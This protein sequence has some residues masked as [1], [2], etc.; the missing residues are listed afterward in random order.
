MKTKIA[1]LL[2]VILATTG[3]GKSNTVQWEY[4]TIFPPDQF[5]EEEM[6]RYG[7]AGWEMVTSRR[8]QDASKTM[9]YEVIMKRKQ[10]NTRELAEQSI[11]LK[12][13]MNPPL[14]P[15]SIPIS[16]PLSPP[17]TSVLDPAAEAAAAA[18]MEADRL[19]TERAEAMFIAR[20]EKEDLV[21][22]GFLQ[23]YPS[24]KAGGM[25]A[26]ANQSGMRDGG[27]AAASGNPL[28]SAAQIS[29]MARAAFAKLGVRGANPPEKDFTAVYGESFRAG[30]AAA[31]A[32]RKNEIARAAKSG[33]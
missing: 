22:D 32:A 30:F 17:P 9:G 24:L 13:K 21:I 6:N 2:L 20:Q 8:A 27:I 4:K 28:P 11:A 10:G 31:E 19:K 18:A 23:R 3:C 15:S 33:L 7:A 12:R 5:F 14:P 29:A 1:A 16:V 25:V 26:F